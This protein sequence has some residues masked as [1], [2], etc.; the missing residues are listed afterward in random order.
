MTK[1]KRLLIGFFLLAL[2]SSWVSSCPLNPAYLGYWENPVL[3]NVVKLACDGDNALITTYNITEISAVAQF[4]PAILT[5][6]DLSQIHQRGDNSLVV[7][8]DIYSR[9][10]D[11][12]T[13]YPDNDASGEDICNVMTNYYRRHYAFFNLHDIDYEQW[14]AACVDAPNNDDDLFDFLSQQISAIPD[15][16][17]MLLEKVDGSGKN[18][19]NF[20]L[21]DSFAKDLQQEMDA[22]TSLVSPSDYIDKILVPQSLDLLRKNRSPPIVVSSHRLF[23][24]YLKQFPDIFYINISSMELNTDQI[25]SF[26]KKVMPLINNQQTARIIFDLRFN[27]GGDDKI[28]QEIIRHFINEPK[29]IYSRQ[30]YYNG[31]QWTEA[32]ATVIKPASDNNTVKPISLLIG[33]ITASA[34]ETFCLGMKSIPRVQFVGENSMGIFS[35]Q[36]P[37]KL[38]NGWWITLSNQKL[39]S[40][41]D[42][43]SYEGSG[44]PVDYPAPFP[45]LSKLKNHIFPGIEMTA[46]VNHVESLNRHS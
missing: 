12:I 21:R 8:G 33:P 2:Y 20:K 30:T 29:K 14:S 45:F 15:N 44:I 27:M 38:P 23:A 4:S 26:M 35:D 17:L 5:S 37:R 28:G 1:T 40:A 18:Y 9:Y 3:G 10:D 34:A 43:I 25:N 31:G 39:L 42:N 11:S 19:F 36:F 7:N 22:D 24:G 13:P 41:D 6:N 16:H 32:E 46:V